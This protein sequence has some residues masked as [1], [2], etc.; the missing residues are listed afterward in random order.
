[1]AEFAGQNN[2]QIFYARF[3]VDE[4]VARYR[5]TVPAKS[6]SAPKSSWPRRAPRTACRR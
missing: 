6:S 1:M 3:D 4:A 2:L 5:A